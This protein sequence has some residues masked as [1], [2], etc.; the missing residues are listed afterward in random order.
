MSRMIDDEETLKD[1]GLIEIDGCN[2]AECRFFIEEYIE[3]F[4]DDNGVR[5]ER[6]CAIE[7]KQCHDKVNCYFKQLQRLKAELEMSKQYAELLKANRCQHHVLN[8]CSQEHHDNC[9]GKKQ[10]I[11][12]L[13]QI[14]SNLIAENDT[15][16]ITIEKL[17]GDLSQAETS[18][19][20]WKAENEKLK[21]ELDDYKRVD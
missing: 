14:I 19:F 6:F 2:V 9:V 5:I 12:D 8:E 10:C 3:D 11:L 7:Q 1:N 16:H 21:K 4:P 20:V 13:E 17:K 18:L 15:L